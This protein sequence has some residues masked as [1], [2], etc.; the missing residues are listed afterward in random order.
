MSLLCLSK[1]KAG[2]HYRGFFTYGNMLPADTP[3][4]DTNELPYPF[5][6]QSG[7]INP[8]YNPDGGLRLSNPSNIK[9]DV[10]YDTKTG[11]YDIYQKVGGMDYRIPTEM[12]SDQYQ[13]YMWRQSEKNYFK[14]KVEAAT[15]ANDPKRKQLIPP[16]KI[17]GK[18]FED[19]FGGNTVN[20]IPQG[21]AELTFGFNNSKM[22][23]PALP[24]AQRSLTT[25]NFDENIQLSVTGQ[26]GTKLKLTTNYNTKATFDFQNQMKLQFM[27]KEDD[28][29]KEIDAGNITFP[30][31]GTL[32]T[33]SQSLFGVKLKTQF[34]RLTSTTA[35]A[36]EKGD[37]KT[38]TVQNGAQTTNFNIKA[39]QYMA[40]QH[41][42]LSQYFRDNYDTA[43]AHPPLVSSG[44]TITRV[45][46]WVTNTSTATQNTRYILAFSDLGESQPDFTEKHGGPVTLNPGLGYT[47]P[48]ARYLPADSVNSIYPRYLERT[49]GVTTPTSAISALT[50]KGFQL[51]TDFEKV[52]LARMLGPSDYTLNPRLGFISL[53][54][55]LNYDQVL[56]VAYQYTYNGKLYQVGQFS[57]DGVPTTN[58][59]VVKMLKST[60]VNTSQPIWKLMS[61]WSRALAFTARL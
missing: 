43:L 55:P 40:N 22:E 19:I 8:L 52:D 34:G 18:L 41:Y 1:A 60:N 48:T 42:F 44:I 50:S 59:L 61:D 4:G 7:E 25:F 11:Q 16:I 31:P 45:E 32:I 3:V 47:S 46:V 56:A 10:Q 53:K 57:T 2:N 17:G 38:I 6:D 49:P 24:V 29:I 13:E 9:T 54:Q 36:Q 33:G 58:E 30:L 37:K 23:N 26:I 14:Q 28:I 51:V 35:Y 15:A 5:I 12:D 39:D 20:I 27:G 21:S